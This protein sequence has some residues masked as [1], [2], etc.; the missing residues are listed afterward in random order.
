MEHVLG[1]ITCTW[2]CLSGVRRRARPPP[3]IRARGA[4]EA[5]AIPPLENELAFGHGE[6]W[7]SVAIQV[8]DRQVY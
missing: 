7:H 5:P 6:V 3:Q 2:G 1:M 4:G 8:A